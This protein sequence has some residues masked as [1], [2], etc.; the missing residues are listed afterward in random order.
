MAV[1][2][3]G[4]KIGGLLVHYYTSTK[5]LLGTRHWARCQAAERLE[6]PVWLRR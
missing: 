5:Q 2:G 1:W 3:V 6:K 4:R